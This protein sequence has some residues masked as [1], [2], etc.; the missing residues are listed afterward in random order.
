MR[1]SDYP[2]DL[3]ELP[4]HLYLLT[5]DDYSPS[6]LA[7]G[8][9]EI[10]DVDRWQYAVEVIFRCL[11]SGL[12]DLGDE[13]VLDDLAVSGYPGLCRGLARLSPAML[14]EEAERFWLN[15]QLASTEKAQE[16]INEFAVE[17]QSGEFKERVM[18]R[19]K[20][21]FADAGV[22]LELG[23]LFPVDVSRANELAEIRRGG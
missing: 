7:G 20:A 8:V 12:W 19:I 15:P 13:S 14:S 3:S 4:W 6:A 9:A 16:L 21:L 5:L 17:G 11:T 18:G 1:L 22:S 23:V 2:V 10:V